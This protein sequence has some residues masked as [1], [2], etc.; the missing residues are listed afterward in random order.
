VQL[1]NDSISVQLLH[2]SQVDFNKYNSSIMQ[3]ISEYGS[4]AIFCQS[5]A[6]L[7][8]FTQTTIDAFAVALHTFLLKTF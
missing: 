5:F 8:S 6:F 1:G 7:F 2:L 3:F 4:F